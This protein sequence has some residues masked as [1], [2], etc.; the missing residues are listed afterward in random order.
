MEMGLGKTALAQQRIG[1]SRSRGERL[2]RDADRGLPQA[3]VGLPVMGSLPAEEKR[4]P[5]DHR[6]HASRDA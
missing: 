5:D 6:N 3:Q 2:R 4:T 1:K